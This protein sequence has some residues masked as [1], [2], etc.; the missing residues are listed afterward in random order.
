[1]PCVEIHPDDAKACGVHD[2]ERV[3]LRSAWGCITLHV[4]LN[5]ALKQGI[6][7]V[8]HGWPEANVNDLIPREFDPASAFPPF[9]EV[10]GAAGTD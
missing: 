7:G 9:K 10:P 3:R 6:V 8:M 2:G 5:P 4:R 1:M